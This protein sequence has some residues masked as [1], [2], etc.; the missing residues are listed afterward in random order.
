MAGVLRMQIEETVTTAQSL[1][2]RAD[3]LGRELADIARNWSD[4]T[5]TWIG[6]AGSA[7]E[8]AWDEWHQDA[9]VVV[10]V[11]QEHSSLLVQSAALLAEH[12]DRASSALGRV[13]DS[14][15]PT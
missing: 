2:N 3:D 9:K 5:G 14:G 7:Y 12:E 15:E 6:K 4:L 11:L 1:A 8:A 13:H 10:A